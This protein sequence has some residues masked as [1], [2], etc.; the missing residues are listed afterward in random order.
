MI[1]NKI[2]INNVRQKEFYSGN[3]YYR[4]DENGI[5]VLMCLDYDGDFF[6]GAVVACTN[7]Q[8]LTDESNIGYIGKFEP[9]RFRDFYGEFT[10]KVTK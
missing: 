10:V 1:E 9:E 6:T 2:S 8:G 4:N 7:R 3:Y 5:V